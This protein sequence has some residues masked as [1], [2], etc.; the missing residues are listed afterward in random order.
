MDGDQLI[1]LLD[2]N[3]DVLNSSFAA[4][5]QEISQKLIEAGLNQHG[6]LKDTHARNITQLLADIILKKGK[7][8]KLKHLKTLRNPAFRHSK[9][10]A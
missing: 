3:E 6:K 8:E 4:T 5:I 1:I 2:A 7:S 9:R 10:C